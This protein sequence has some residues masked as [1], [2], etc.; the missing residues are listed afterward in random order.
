M[1]QGNR[2]QPTSE[3]MV[4]RRD[5]LKASIVTALNPSLVARRLHAEASGIWVNDAHSQLNPTRILHLVQ[6]SSIG[7]VQEAIRTVGSKGQFLSIAGARH[8]AGGQQFAADAP[9][10]DLS[11]M[12]RVLHFDS[13][14]GLVEVEAGVRWPE[15]DAFLLREQRG[16]SSRWCAAQKQG[17]PLMSLGGT[18]SA[19]AHGN[20]VGRGP[21]VSDVESFELVDARAKVRHC[22]RE[23]NPDLFRL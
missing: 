12:K 5:F 20:T 10:L 19:N 8:A 4:T 9:L 17:V 3:D 15:L 16:K 1:E 11:R 7:D 22:S 2:P 14:G 13:E 6:P 23:E 18:L 21:I